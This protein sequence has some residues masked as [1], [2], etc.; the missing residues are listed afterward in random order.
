MIYQSELLLVVY[1]FLS[2]LLK[3]KYGRQVNS[4]WIFIVVFFFLGLEDDSSRA[5][6]SFHSPKH[7]ESILKALL[8]FGGCM[9]SY[10]LKGQ[11]FEKQT[12]VAVS[13]FG[14][15][16]AI[17][18]R[19]FLSL[20]IALEITT[21]PLHWMF[22]SDC[23]RKQTAQGTIPLLQNTLKLVFT[24]EDRSVAP[25]F[26]FAMVGTGAY[27]LAIIWMYLSIES[28]DF[29]EIRYS[30]SFG[31]G[32]SHWWITFL[33][34]NSLTIKQV[35]CP[36]YLWLSDTAHGKN[37]LITPYPLQ[38]ASQI[39]FYKLV[40]NVF[41]YLDGI[42][43]LLTFGFLLMVCSSFSLIFQNNIKQIV[44]RCIL[45]QMGTMFLCCAFPSHNGLQ[46]MMFSMLAMIISFFGIS[47]VLKSR[48]INTLADLPAIHRGHM[49][50]A[51]AIS[52]IF[53]S[54]M[55]Y[56]PFLG[57]WSQF[58]LCLALM[59]WRTAASVIHLVPC[60][61]NMVCIAKILDAIWFPRTQVMPR[62]PPD[63]VLRKTIYLITLMLIAIVPLVNRVFSP[64]RVESYFVR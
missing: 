43:I 35:V 30:I 25:Y 24:A 40:T 9:V 21:I 12:A 50:S 48:N 1:I 13:V 61:F 8:L 16:M 10:A 32:R 23:S 57:F 28:L 19:N 49:L 4:F 29:S 5:N 59:G 38:M 36:I 62:L 42:N 26:I 37:L 47:I 11:D 6:F 52:I 2:R 33:M 31:H 20:F 51:A 63:H 60:V 39:I 55:G 14:S 3:K 27:A 54:L 34:L 58:Y 45:S 56:P 41:Y 53:L 7:A 17:S 18:A 64:V 15:L 22:W 44:I 46:A